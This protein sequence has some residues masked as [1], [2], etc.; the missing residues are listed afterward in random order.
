MNN[1]SVCTYNVGSRIDD[2]FQLCRHLDPSLSFKNSEEEEAFRSKYDVVQNRTAELLTNKAEVYCLQ[3]VFNEERPLIQSLKEKAFEI[4]HLEGL[5]YFDTAIALDK[6]RFKDITNHSFDVQITTHFKKDVAIAT[7]TD[8]LTGQ[9]I[10]FVSAHAPG[11]DFTKEVS[12]KDAAE[13]DFYCRAII[14]KLSEIGNSTIHVIGADMNANPEKWDP[15]F[16][17]FSNQGFQLNRKNSATNVNPK[18]S[19]EQEREIDFI[20]TKTSSSNWQKTKSIFFSTI[21]FETAIKD[22]N[23]I[24]WNIDDNASDHLPIFIGISAKISVSK[25]CLLW[26]ATCSCFRAQQ[27]QTT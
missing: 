7:A 2:Y 22:E 5:A 17:V 20:F 1:F 13:G 26:N 16:R 3:E 27:L 8:V 10:T 6:D 14:N 4:I 23:S 18:D 24:G 19:T 15:R 21:Q 25:I 11:F 9:R 12:D